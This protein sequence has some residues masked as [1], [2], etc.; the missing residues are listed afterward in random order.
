MAARTALFAA[1]VNTT[2]LVRTPGQVLFVVAFDCFG[3]APPALTPSFTR[4]GKQ[5]RTVLRAIF[6]VLAPPHPSDEEPHEE[7]DE[8][9]DHEREEHTYEW[10]CYLRR[11]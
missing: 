10:T 1:G 9:T 7:N 11:W 4:S 5:L 8:N 3:R 6:V 2:S